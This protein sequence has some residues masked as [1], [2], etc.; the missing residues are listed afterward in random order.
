M[1]EVKIDK[2][3]S[4]VEKKKKVV[5]FEVSSASVSRSQPTDTEPS[6]S[7]TESAS[8]LNRP[9]LKRATPS[10]EYQSIENEGSFQEIDDQF[11]SF[12]ISPSR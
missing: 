6:Q 3:E 4:G 7:Y 2:P 9:K 8:D 10:K 11:Q 5:Q 1:L 12:R